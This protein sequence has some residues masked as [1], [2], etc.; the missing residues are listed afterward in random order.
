MASSS[1]VARLDQIYAEIVRD[2]RDTAT[3][4]SAL[5]ERGLPPDTGDA[6]HRIRCG[7]EEAQV[8]ME[9]LI[10][11]HPNGMDEAMALRAHVAEIAHEAASIWRSPPN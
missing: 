4:L 8:R 5:A 1:A 10:S 7:I 9:M 2:C 3:I 6:L 11:R